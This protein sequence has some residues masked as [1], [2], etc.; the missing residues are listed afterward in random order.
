MTLNFRISIEEDDA[1]NGVYSVKEIDALFGDPAWCSKHVIGLESYFAGDD[2]EVHKR[3]KEYL[4]RCERE[5][6]GVPEAR[7]APSKK[8]KV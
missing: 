6:T 7:K 4:D 1:L 2:K 8:E 3:V 5:G